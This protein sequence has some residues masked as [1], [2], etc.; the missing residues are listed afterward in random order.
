MPLLWSV[1]LVSH[2]L[3]ALP[4]LDAVALSVGLLL[5]DVVLP[6]AHGVIA[7]PLGALNPPHEDLSPPEQISLQHVAPPEQ[8][9]LQPVVPPVQLS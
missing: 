5:G 4:L 9:S 8:L 1:E 3:R 2:G 7:H 6:P